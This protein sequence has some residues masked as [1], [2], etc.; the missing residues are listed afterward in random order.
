MEKMIKTAKE[1]RLLSDMDILTE[2]NRV[3]SLINKITSDVLNIS[4]YK[5]KKQWLECLFDYQR[6]M[7]E[8]I[9]LYERVTK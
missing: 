9:E 2:K 3:I 4:D 8:Y 1:R 5:G 7:Q 6:E